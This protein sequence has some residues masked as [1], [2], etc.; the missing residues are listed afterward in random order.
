MRLVPVN[1]LDEAVADGC[2]DIWSLA[3]YFEVTEEFMREAICWYTHGNMA[4]ELYF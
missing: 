2:T 1:K 3:E 4:A